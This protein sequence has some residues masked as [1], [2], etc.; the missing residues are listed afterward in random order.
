[1]APTAQYGHGGS[2]Q[3]PRS[4]RT[5]AASVLEA[6]A[7]QQHQQ[8]LSAA[9]PPEKGAEGEKLKM[10]SPPPCVEGSPVREV[11]LHV[12]H[13]RSSPLGIVHR[14]LSQGLDSARRLD[15]LEWL[16]QAFDALSL[17]DSQLFAAF[18]LLDRY[19]AASPAPIAAG[20][21]AFAL[22]LAA[23][24][25]ALKVTGTQ[26]DLDRA[27]RLVVEV[28]GSS[29]PWSAVRRAE[30]N[31]LRRLSF[32][33]CTPHARDLLERLLE[34]QARL[35]PEQAF[36]A[37][38]SDATREHCES[39]ARFLLELAVVYEAEAVYGP[40]RAPLASAL[41][42]MLVAL[43]ATG[44]PRACIDVLREPFGIVESAESAVGDIA[45]A[46]ALRWEREE[47]RAK[48]ANTSAV[49][50]KWLRRA[51]PLQASPPSAAE[52]R[53]LTVT[54]SYAP[55]PP[56]PPPAMARDPAR[57]PSP[58]RR[59]SLDST[60]AAVAAA[61]SAVAAAAA[62][63]NQV[64]SSMQP[65]VS[66]QPV[67]TPRAA[68]AP[69]TTH[70]VAQANA[71]AALPTAAAKYPPVQ[72]VSQLSRAVATENLSSW[73]TTQQVPACLSDM[74]EQ[75]EKKQVRGI[76]PTAVA[77]LQGSGIHQA[78]EI[79]G[80][81]GRQ[82]EASSQPDAALVELTH[83]L[84]M[85]A[86]RPA[87]GSATHGY[88]AGKEAASRRSE[89]QSPQ[90]AKPRS[91]SN[92]VAS[93]LLMSSAL[94]MQWP[95]DRRKVRNADAAQ[96]CRDAAMVLQEAANKLLAAAGDLDSGHCTARDVKPLAAGPPAGESRR[97]K[98]YSG[99]GPSPPRVAS[100]TGAVSGAVVGPLV[101]VGLRV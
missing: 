15:A 2:S 28:S 11:S 75:N 29:R 60:A 73:P 13:Q 94:R 27:K 53:S 51:G 12:L 99:P 95:V 65:P 82:A 35:Q 57:P 68:L 6:A 22:V 10:R 32:R 36:P 84:N 34:E 14:S 37:A 45:E 80:H 63:A 30:I 52:V 21:G 91:S 93:E 43:I 1:M 79:H 38:W 17:P 44:A 78:A 86:P 67:P 9:V 61:A 47:M 70:Q 26:K 58:L 59:C 50:E 46:L 85:V 24:L 23:M 39:L 66:S 96:H 16:V 40:G 19:A 100:P 69:T 4:S 55:S 98:T 54:L 41:A 92:S 76:E 5:S 33:A 81:V 71:P 7:R 3:P 90:Q 97:R 49:L 89:G 20:P 88:G 25:V 8:P 48:N 83:V 74:P 64:S 62:T 18:G 42:A 56:V 77:A 87:Q 31:I 72:L 101:R